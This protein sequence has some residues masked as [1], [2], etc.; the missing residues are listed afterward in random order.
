LIFI[1]LH[2]VGDCS[3][4]CRMI[5]L[6]ILVTR[7][8]PFGEELCQLFVAQGD[9]AIYLPTL[10]IVNLPV[11]PELVKAIKNITEQD[12]LV[13]I[14]PQAVLSSMPLL[15]Q[16]CS[17][18]PV[19]TQIIAMGEGT[20]K[21]LRKAGLR[22]DV[23]PDK[24][25]SSEELLNL[26]MLTAV[27]GKKITLVRGEGGREILQQLLAESGA[28]VSHIVTYRRVMP[29]IDMQPY[30]ELLAT[31]PWQVT[32]CTSG[33]SIKN[34]KQLFADAAWPALSV[35]PLIVVSE[36]I[37]MLA[38][39]LGFQTIWVARQMSNSALLEC[40]AEKRQVLC[41]KS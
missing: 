4:L 2:V 41:Q 32:V 15:R 14:S 26:F 33:E 12:S 18:I 23:Y 20:A 37:K 29:E 34:L 30:R 27:A 31:H 40:L 28:I 8:A 10:N 22:V 7:P 1:I 19:T 3:I 25:Y 6:H 17:V 11:S 16:Y 38:E 13:F 39:D 9:K 36:R 35:I 24:V 21:L 5:P